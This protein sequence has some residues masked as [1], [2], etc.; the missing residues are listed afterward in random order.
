MSTPPLP[1]PEQV[2]PCLMVPHP[3]MGTL[4]EVGMTKA[5]ADL[6][7]VQDLFERAESTLGYDLKKVTLC[8][9]GDGTV[10]CDDISPLVPFSCH[11]N[12]LMTR[13]R[14]SGATDCHGGAFDEVERDGVLPASIVG[15]WV[16]V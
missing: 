10:N 2:G 5:E 6:P 16:R 8:I 4:Q 3:T 7:A 15:C 14:S 9:G 1:S 11:G 12:V 13:R